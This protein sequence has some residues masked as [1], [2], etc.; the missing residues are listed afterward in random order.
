MK[1]FVSDTLNKLFNENILD[2]QVKWEYMKYNIRKYTINFSKTLAKNSNKQIVDLKT[3]LKHFE[4][5]M[6]I[7]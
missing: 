3:K 7:T 6:L 1:K 4:K 5:S 2:D